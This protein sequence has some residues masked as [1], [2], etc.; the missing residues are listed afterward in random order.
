[1]SLF[2]DLDS[3]PS[4]REMEAVKEWLLSKHVVHVMRDH[5][6]HD[7]PILAGMWGMK[8][9]SRR[10]LR[11]ALRALF[12]VILTRPYTYQVQEVSSADQALLE[13]YLWPLLAPLALQ[14][15]SY[16]CQR[17]AKS[18]AWPSQRAENE[19]NNYVG[20][21]VALNGL[22]NQS[23]PIKCRPKQHPEWTLC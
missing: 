12:L 5:P 13:K 6:A 4:Q 22:L 23:C 16:Q 9:G 14:H 8:L 20:A 7:M 10:G 1:M 17:F 19:P 21:P 11:A 18:H 2:R 3:R 15:D